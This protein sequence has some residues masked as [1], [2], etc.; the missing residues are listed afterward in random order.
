MSLCCQE[1]GWATST[2]VFEEEKVL[3]TR[4][5]WWWR[6]PSK[7]AS[8]AS[9]LLMCPVCLLGSSRVFLFGTVSEHCKLLICRSGTGKQNL[10]PSIT[11]GVYGEARKTKGS[12]QV[13]VL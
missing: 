13:R 6:Q 12:L 3:K 1:E 10:S 2:S 11:V 4:W 9:V 7:V 5:W 8:D